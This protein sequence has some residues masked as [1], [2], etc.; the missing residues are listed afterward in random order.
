VLELQD[1]RPID[2]ITVFLDPD[3]QGTFEIFGA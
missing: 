2:K 1:D 3:S